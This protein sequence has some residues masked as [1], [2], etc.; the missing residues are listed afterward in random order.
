MSQR[1]FIRGIDCVATLHFDSNNVFSSYVISG[2]CRFIGDSGI[3]RDLRL[4][5]VFVRHKYGR[6][7]FRDFSIYLPKKPGETFDYAVWNRHGF[8][9]KVSVV[10]DG[11]QLWAQESVTDN[12]YQ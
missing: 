8:T 6:P 9:I 11:G 1:I 3:T 4:F 12:R 7:K 5:Y 2:T 10:Y